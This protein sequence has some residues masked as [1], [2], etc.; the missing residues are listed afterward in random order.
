MDGKEDYK[1]ITSDAGQTAYAKAVAEGLIEFLNLKEKKKEAPKKETTASTVLY[2]VRKTWK[3]EKSQKG[4]Y[5][6]L[7]SAK[8]LADN[9]PGYKVFDENGKVVY[10]PAKKSAEE[11]AKEV[12]AGKWGN[13]GE[14]RKKLEEAGYNYAEVQKWVNYLIK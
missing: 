13:G 5:K 8:K 3:D 10:T 2:R 12:L 4:A 1:I 14:R 11:I 7:A 6:T 9:N